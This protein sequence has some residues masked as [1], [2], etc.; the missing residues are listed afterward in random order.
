MFG[1]QYGI[2]IE[3]GQFKICWCD[4]NISGS[5]INQL[6]EI[7]GANT[8]IHDDFIGHG[9]LLIHW[10]EV[11]KIADVFNTMLMLGLWFKTGNCA[12]V[13]FDPR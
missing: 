11:L 2:G 10:T 1:Y 12:R 9:Y 6:K 5:T 3:K 4:E 7:S 8:I 13:T